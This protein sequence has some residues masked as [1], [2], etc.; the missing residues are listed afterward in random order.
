MARIPFELN[1]EIKDAFVDRIMLYGKSSIVASRPSMSQVLRSV[2]SLVVTMEDSILSDFLEV[3]AKSELVLSEYLN[4]FKECSNKNLIPQNFPAINTEFEE[5][6]ELMQN[7]KMGKISDDEFKEKIAI[8][9][10]KLLAYKA[11]HKGTT[12]LMNR[13]GNKGLLNSLSPKNILEELKKDNVAKHVV[14][15]AIKENIRK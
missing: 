1:D 4:L 6:Y 15:E 3:A 13:L 10:I 11:V 12:E 9:D 7:L 8:M 2:V 14:D 5:I